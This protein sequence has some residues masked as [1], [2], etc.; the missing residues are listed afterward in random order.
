MNNPC[1]KPREL[2]QPWEVGTRRVGGSTCRLI[3]IISVFIRCLLFV[4]TPA[5]WDC[6]SFCACANFIPPP[7][8]REPLRPQSLKRQCPILAVEQ[9]SCDE[10]KTADSRGGV[11]L[12]V[13]AG[14]SSLALS[15]LSLGFKM[16]LLSRVAIISA[17]LGS[18]FQLLGGALFHIDCCGITVNE[19]W[20][21]RTG[22]QKR[23]YGV[24]GDL[25]V[26]FVLRDGRLAWAK[27]ARLV[28]RPT[29]PARVTLLAAML[30]LK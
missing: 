8:P 15:S 6:N 18:N 23:C 9:I 14:I 7:P 16:Y 19:S 30:D 13:G 1:L 22:K 20:V 17:A 28:M 4:F 21:G 27:L 2:A 29:P 3:V 25:K 26:Y 5:C 10:K 11:W 12:G 24:G